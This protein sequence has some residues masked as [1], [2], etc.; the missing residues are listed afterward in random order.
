[1]VFI[2]DMNDSNCHFIFKD[3]V[4]KQ[5]YMGNTYLSSNFNEK[6]PDDLFINK[7]KEIIESKKPVS[8]ESPVLRLYKKIR[9]K[10][11]VFNESEKIDYSSVPPSKRKWWKEAVVYQIYPKSFKDTDGDGTG[12]IKGIIQKL[13]YLKGLGVDTL[14][15]TPVSESPEVDNGY[16]ISNYRKINPR[17]GSMKDMEELIDKAHEKNMHVLV[18]MVFNHTSDKHRWF[19]ASADPN[20]PEHEKYKDYYIWAD[21]ENPTPE[22]PKGNPPD[23]MKS[24]FEMPAWTYNEK[25]GQYYFHLFYREQPSL[26]WKNPEVRKDIKKVAN[27]WLKKKVDGFRMDVIDMIGLRKPDYNTE[28]QTL[29]GKIFQAII[30]NDLLIQLGNKLKETALPLT[31]AASSFVNFPRLD[32]HLKELMEENKDFKPHNPEGEIMTVGETPITSLSKLPYV[33]GNDK[34][35]MTFNFDLVKLG[36]ENNSIWTTRRMPIDGIKRIIT[37][38]QRGTEKDGLWYSIYT[39]NHDQPR[40]VSQFGNDSTEEFRKSSAKMLATMNLTLRGTPFIFQGEELGMPNARFDSIEGYRDKDTHNVYST[41]LKEAAQEAKNSISGQGLMEKEFESF[42]KS[43]E[44]EA[45]NDIWKKIQEKSRDNSRTPMQ[46][47]SSGKAGF[48]TGKPWIGFVKDQSA[49][50]KYAPMDVV[51]ETARPDSVL[52][53]YKKMI[54]IR[55]ENPVL[56]YG[57]YDR[58]KQNRSIVSKFVNFLNPERDRIFAYTRTLKDKKALIVLNYSDKPNTFSMTDYNINSRNLKLL[59]NSNPTPERD[60]NNSMNLKPYEARVYLV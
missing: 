8:G 11:Y 1:M 22:D 35:N 49:N 21:P 33:V 18:D 30:K 51:S 5:A 37:K 17:Y 25:R 43:A 48:T 7:V 55:K 9:T 45:K 28:P 42:V 12:D 20:H 39:G 40:T 54:K 58:L 16:D 47:D 60:E 26:N 31:H 3:Q 6:T 32:K 24:F 15:L 4:K 2:G 38:W 34:L 46:W 44:K 27:F 23:P 41:T 59:I 52:N 57:E 13:D 53:Y 14:W 29:S 50:K 36:M 10:K 56:I 19:E